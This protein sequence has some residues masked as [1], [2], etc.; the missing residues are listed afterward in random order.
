MDKAQPILTNDIKE[1]YYYSAGQ[2]WAIISRIVVMQ[3]FYS[4]GANHWKHC[5]Q[6]WWPNSCVPNFFSLHILLKQISEL[7]LILYYSWEGNI[8]TLITFLHYCWMHDPYNITFYII[9]CFQSC[10]IIIF[11]NLG[12]LLPQWCTPMVT[13]YY[14]YA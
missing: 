3:Q 11:Q 5:C 6:T 14:K 13:I 8:N 12:L 1:H 7:F 9:F 2:N 10:Y 4:N